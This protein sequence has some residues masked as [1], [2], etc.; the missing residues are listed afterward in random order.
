LIALMS[1]F[2]PVTRS[3]LAPLPYRDPSRIA[4]VSDGGAALATRFAIRAESVRLWQSRSKLLE[5]AEAYLWKESV[6]T[7]S[8]GRSSRLLGARVSD[9]FFFLLGARSSEG[10]VFE[11]N[12]WANCGDCVIVSYRFWK[13]ALNGKRLTPETSMRLDGRRYR[14]AAVLEKDFWFL[15][16]EISVWPVAPLASFQGEHASVVVRLGPDVVPEEAEHELDSLVREANGGLRGTGFVRIAPV[17]GRVRSVIGSFGLALALAIVTAAGSSRLRFSRMNLR[18]SIFFAAKTLLLLTAVFLTGLE[19][20]R[21]AAIN[22]LG[23]ADLAT[24]PLSTWLF[25]LGGMGVL[26]WSVS[27]QQARCRVCLKRLGLRTRVGCPG[28]L[29]LDW[30]GTELVC[31]EGHGMLHIPEMVSSW[32]QPDHWTPLDDSWRALFERG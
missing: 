6:A 31:V 22:M 5:G 26:L 30:A 20:T 8:S 2:L 10:R 12:Q 15:S 32:S 19:F 3:I 21:A 13:V 25:L 7:E 9:N 11:R 16:R 4:T 18:G 1:G 27:D 29:L 23:G 24:E 17:S 28:C 14:V